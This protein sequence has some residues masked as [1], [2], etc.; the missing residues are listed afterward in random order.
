MGLA[1]LASGGHSAP[2]HRHGSS[3]LKVGA[4]TPTPRLNPNSPA[5]PMPDNNCYFFSA[6]RG[7]KM[8]STSLKNQKNTTYMTVYQ[9]RLKELFA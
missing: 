1:A 4:T 6:E 2:K 9:Q 7:T 8:A 3:S 5:P